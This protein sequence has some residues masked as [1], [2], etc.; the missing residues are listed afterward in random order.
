MSTLAVDESAIR[1]GEGPFQLIP[2]SSSAPAMSRR[3][4][5]RVENSSATPSGAPPEAR[6]SRTI[7]TAARVSDSASGASM[8]SPTGTGPSGSGSAAS[9]GASPTS[10]NPAAHRV[11]ANPRIGRV[12]GA[13]ADDSQQDQEIARSGDRL[14]QT[15]LGGAHLFWQVDDEMNEVSGVLTPADL[16]DGRRDEID[17]IEPAPDESFPHRRAQRREVAAAGANR[18]EALGPVGPELAHLLVDLDELLLGRGVLGDGGEER[19]TLRA[20]RPGRRPRAR[21]ASAGGGPRAGR[22]GRP[23][24]RRDRPARG[25]AG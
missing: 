13:V 1:S 3:Y 14:E 19:R 9:R 2:A 18:G 15:R 8:V 5:S 22:P 20:A 17:V 4:G 12:G 16:G 21:P 7:R 23:A 24:P 10:W 11:L 25:S 6:C